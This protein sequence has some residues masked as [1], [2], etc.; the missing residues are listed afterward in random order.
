M[1]GAR[2]LLSP[3]LWVRLLLAAALL[4]WVVD[5]NGPERI[6]RA[7]LAADP[8]WA[9]A[10]G[11][12]FLLSIAG[13]AL[14][15]F[16]LLRLQ[17]FEYGLKACFRSYY[18]GM[19]LNNFMP[20]TVGGDALRVWDVH[21]SQSA[22]PALPGRDGGLGKAAA[23]T[24]LDRLFGFSAL[25]LFSLLALVYELQRRSLPPDLVR[26]LFWAVSAVSFSFGM[27]LLLLLSRRLSAVFHAVIR[28]VGLNRLDAA[29]A[30]VQD[31]LLAYKARWG[32]MS[33]VFAVACVV[34]LLR[35]SV[36]LL[37]A[38]ALSLSLSPSLFLSVIPLIALAAVLPLNVGGWGVPQGLGAY[39]YGLPGILGPAAANADFDTGAAATALAFLP[40][41][42]GMVVMLGGGFYFVV[43]R[44]K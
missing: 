41:V 33:G 9:A 3:W 8:A 44:K 36:H 39:L 27:L 26:H 38:W 5:R 11:L 24:L 35:V 20:G 30:K 16:M 15:W 23:A 42:I 37:S 7:L 40:S 21:R 29:Y 4:Y 2:G 34:Q 25:A 10:A 19:F 12:C 43:G 18:S 14:Q 22:A 1:P 28:Q 31:S 13:G 6:A 17:G 32:R